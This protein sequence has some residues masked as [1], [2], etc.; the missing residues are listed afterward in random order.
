MAK[1]L[2]YGF[3]IG[4]HGTRHL[5]LMVPRKL[6]EDA[7]EDRK[8][9]RYLSMLAGNEHQAIKL[10]GLSKG[11]SPVRVMINE[12]RIGKSAIK[13]VLAKAVTGALVCLEEM[14][15]PER[16]DPAIKTKLAIDPADPSGR[17]ATHFTLTWPTGPESE[18]AEIATDAM[19]ES[20]SRLGYSK[21]YHI[22]QEVFAKVNRQ[23]YG[24]RLRLDRELDQYLRTNREMHD[25]ASKVVELNQSNLYSHEQQ[26]ICL[27]GSVA[28]AHADALVNI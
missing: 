23:K 21:P 18:L 28:I 20:A 12:K 8:L 14:A 5:A 4:K 1:T 22:G 27:A 2:E 26:L 25:P 24:I 13:P 19:F 16:Q 9:S 10:L 17:L 3:E 15:G 6:W 11:R 7:S